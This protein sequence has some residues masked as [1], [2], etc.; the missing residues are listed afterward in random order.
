MYGSSNKL[1][2]DLWIASLHDNIVIYIFATS[3]PHCSSNDRKNYD[4][5]SARRTNLDFANQLSR[6]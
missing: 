1:Y 4:T 5:A 6:F 2:V 3:K